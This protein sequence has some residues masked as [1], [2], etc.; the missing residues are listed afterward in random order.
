VGVGLG[1]EKLYQRRCGRRRTDQDRK[2]GLEPGDPHQCAIQHGGM[3][4]PL[5]GPRLDKPGQ[6]AIRS[7]LPWTSA[8][9]GKRSPE[10][11]AVGGEMKNGPDRDK[12]ERIRGDGG[13]KSKTVNRPH[14]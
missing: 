14:S 8:P 1:G 11:G 13:K 2:R 3:G 9:G 5:L 12:R 10:R 7:E 6:V 4:V